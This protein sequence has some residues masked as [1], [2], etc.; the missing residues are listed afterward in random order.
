MRGL[1]L[2]FQTT[3]LLSPDLALRMAE[4]LFC[5]PRRHRTPE[6]EL[7]AGRNGQPFAFRSQG[8]LLQ[9][10]IWGEGPPVALLHGW[11][12]R[13]TQFHA[14]LE[15][16]L[17]A[18]YSAVAFDEPAH[19]A[20]QGRFAGPLEW[21]Q[22]IGAFAREVGP[23]HGVVAHSLGAPALA[24]ALDQGLL[25][26]PRAV[27]LAPPAEPDIFYSG[28]LSM[29][30]LPE[31]DHAQAFE[32]FGARIGIPW[33]RIRLRSLAPR[34]STALLVIHDRQDRDVPWESGATVASAWPDAR[35]LLTEGLGHRRIL[36]DP[37]VIEQTVAFLGQAPTSAALP[38]HGEGPRSLEWHLFHR[39]LRTA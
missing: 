27:F 32:A 26:L 17:A 5:L 22:A 25:E 3:R 16:L 6:A 2:G 35:L 1:R 33:D 7:A 12:G 9:G 19:G 39:E 8:F 4:R 34:R 14:F 20:S 38:F 30:G 11:E 23:L 24:I 31:R 21:S 37:Q 10:R 28:L 36:R 29:L 18:G 15:P 13:G